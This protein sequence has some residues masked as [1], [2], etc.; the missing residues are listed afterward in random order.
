MAG[1]VLESYNRLAQALLLA[2]KNLELPV[3]MKELVGNVQRDKSP[4][5]LFALKCPL[6][7]RSQWMEKS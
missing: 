4:S 2:V 5:T 6:P 7:M 3:E 1:S